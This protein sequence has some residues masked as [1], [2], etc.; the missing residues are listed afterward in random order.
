M[1]SSGNP[2]SQKNLAEE[3]E[4]NEK[5]VIFPEIVVVRRKIKQ[6]RV[7]LASVHPHSPL[8]NV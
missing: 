7:S 6:I 4:T 2:T 3:E 8:R 5:D 1:L